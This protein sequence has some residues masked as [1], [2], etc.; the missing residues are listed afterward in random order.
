MKL[1]SFFLVTVLF[2][3]GP[4]IGQGLQVPLYDVGALA[5]WETLDR[6]DTPPYQAEKIAAQWLFGARS[7]ASSYVFITRIDNTLERPAYEAARLLGFFNEAGYA[8]LHPDRFQSEVVEVKIAGNGAL[9][10]V[11]N[12]FGTARLGYEVGQGTGAARVRSVF[13]PLTVWNE[14][15]DEYFNWIYVADFRG[16]AG[17]TSDL[18]AFDRLWRSV[19]L[20][21]GWTLIDIAGF[22]ALRPRLSASRK[23][24][25]SSPEPRMETVESVEIG[26]DDLVRAILD[27]LSGHG[28]EQHDSLFRDVRDAY[29]ET[30][31]AGV[32]D[33]VLSVSTRTWERRVWERSMAL[34]PAEKHP[35]LTA[36]FLAESIARGRRDLAREIAEH[37]LE[38]VGGVST[39]ACEE[40]DLL[41]DGLVRSPVIASW[42]SEPVREF[43]HLSSEPACSDLVEMLQGRGFVLS[44]IESVAIQKRNGF[45]TPNAGQARPEIVSFGE[46]LVH[47]EAISRKGEIWWKPQR[48]SNLIEVIE[49]L[50]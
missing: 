50:R 23:T 41:L 35:R 19:H 49:A 15:R 38:P 48:I 10:A 39:L 17:S 9:A 3:T 25:E 21:E 27:T 43:F 45:W 24:A 44:R 34:A 29:P 30:I 16:S 1:R 32:L 33:R 7:S 4:L 47:L 6:E 36:L 2:T 37:S 13:L 40:V 28:S 20:P 42:T 26:E 22:N 5:G 11:L 31:V 8:D 14:S 18:E 12:S 46:K